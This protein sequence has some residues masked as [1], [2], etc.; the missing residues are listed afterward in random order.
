MYQVRVITLKFILLFF[1]GNTFTVKE[2]VESKGQI[3][4]IN[5]PIIQ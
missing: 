3:I 2:N 1:T 4:I 5:D